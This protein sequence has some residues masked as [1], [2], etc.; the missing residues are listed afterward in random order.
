MRK[1]Q[2]PVA[3]SCVRDHKCR[4]L[5]D[6]SAEYEEGRKQTCVSMSCVSCV[7]VCVSLFWLSA[8]LC[9]GATVIATS[10]HYMSQVRTT[11]RTAYDPWSDACDWN[12]RPACASPRCPLV[13]S[14][15]SSLLHRHS[16]MSPATTRKKKRARKDG[17]IETKRNKQSIVPGEEG[18]GDKV[19]SGP[20]GTWVSRHPHGLCSLCFETQHTLR[21]G[22]AGIDGVKVPCD[23]VVGRI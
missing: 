18:A 4:R 13:T 3:V 16:T 17:K 7:F 9:L 15:V 20:H 1:R 21:D 8:A 23:D 14:K 6:V 10:A 12:S 2:A 19:S 5:K 22:D 11:K